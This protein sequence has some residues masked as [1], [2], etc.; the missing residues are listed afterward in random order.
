MT[1]QSH[2]LSMPVLALMSPNS[3]QNTAKLEA[4]FKNLSH[5]PQDS[6]QELDRTHT[7]FFNSF[8]PR[9]P[10]SLSNAAVVLLSLL[11]QSLPPSGPVTITCLLHPCSSY[12]TFSLL[13]G[14]DQ[15]MHLGS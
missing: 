10:Y 5:Y 7:L 12:P 15:K 8:A 9:K 4:L 13:S 1:V 6:K 3:K 2:L 11:P 14:L